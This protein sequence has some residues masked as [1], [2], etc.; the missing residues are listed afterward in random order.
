MSKRS[1]QIVGVWLEPK[2]DGFS[3]AIEWHII[4]VAG[5]DYATACGLDGD[6]AYAGTFGTEPARPGTRVTCM[7]CRTIWD[8]FRS[9]RLRDSDFERDR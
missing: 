6:D 4:N 2:A 3:E 1:E 8:G 9:L 5:T 7:Q